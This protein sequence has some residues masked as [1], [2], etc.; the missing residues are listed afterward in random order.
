MLTAVLQ[1]LYENEINVSLSCFWDGGWDIKIGDLLNGWKATA[2][3]ENDQLD[4]TAAMWLTAQAVALYP[5]SPFAAAR[6]NRDLV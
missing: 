1:E 6:R 4:T 2:V 5:R 3:F